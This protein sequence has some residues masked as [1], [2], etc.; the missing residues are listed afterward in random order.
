MMLMTHEELL[1]VFVDK[2]SA[3]M[4]TI[5]LR[6]FPVTGR[7][8]PGVRAVYAE[9]SRGKKVIVV[10]NAGIGP[11]DDGT[12]VEIEVENVWVEGVKLDPFHLVCPTSAVVPLDY[13]AEGA[14]ARDLNEVLN[15]YADE[16]L[17]SVVEHSV[18][19]AAAMAARLG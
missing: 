12:S 8:W 1:G 10:M 7:I 11:D 13:D 15:S 16:L 17:N 9:E 6:G 5:F 3:E 2:A 4:P 19:L 18:E 14:D